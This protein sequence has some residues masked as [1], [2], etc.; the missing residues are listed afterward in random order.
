MSEFKEFICE[1]KISEPRTITY[2]KWSIISTGFGNER[3]IY[4]ARN[5][6]TKIG[7]RVDTNVVYWVCEIRIFNKIMPE[8]YHWLVDT[9]YVSIENVF[10]YDS[11]EDVDAFMWK[12]VDYIRHAR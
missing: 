2:G 5:G 11:W 12:I 4:V 6:K 3:Y 10:W 1:S 7:M 8:C 9:C